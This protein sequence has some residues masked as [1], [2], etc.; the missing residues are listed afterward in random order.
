MAFIRIKKGDKENGKYLFSQDRYYRK[1]TAPTA[2]VEQYAETVNAA[3]VYEVSVDEVNKSCTMPEV[4]EE[5]VA[6]YYTLN[7][8]WSNGTEVFM[9]QTSSS[10]ERVSNIVVID[11]NTQWKSES[12]PHSF[13]LSNGNIVVVWEKNIYTTMGNPYTSQCTEIFAKIFASD[14]TVVKETFQVSKKQFF[15]VW[16]THREIIQDGEHATFTDTGESAWPLPAGFV[17]RNLNKLITKQSNPF[18]VCLSDDSFVIFWDNYSN[19]YYP[20]TGNQNSF[21]T[22]NQRKKVCYSYFDSSGNIIR[23]TGGYATLI[24]DSLLSSNNEVWMWEPSATVMSDDKVYY[25]CTSVD[26]ASGNNKTK[27]AYGVIDPLHWTDASAPFLLND[28]RSLESYTNYDTH[29]TSICSLNSTPSYWVATWTSETYN[30]DDEFRTSPPSSTQIGD[31][32][33]VLRQIMGTYSATLSGSD[34]IIP[35]P[36]APTESGIQA[37]IY[38]KNHQINSDV[39]GLVNG[40][41]V[42]VWQSY[43]QDGSGWGIYARIFNHIGYPMSHE[44]PVNQTTIN[45]QYNPSVTV[46]PDG[47]FMVSWCDGDDETNNSIKG[48]IYTDL[49]VPVGEEFY[50]IDATGVSGLVTYAG[51]AGLGIG[52]NQ[53]VRTNTGSYNFFNWTG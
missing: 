6:T 20:T 35:Y 22:P 45:N 34:W 14:G 48:R 51:D 15:D 30:F 44:I 8:V 23:I 21:I 1:I 42:M 49:G 39:K 5:P 32:A 33:A 36:E 16:D 26:P 19:L 24:S 13:C 3:D 25:T 52:S 4:T 27:I 18:G 53:K 31:S 17:T 46:M 12:S 47:N 9:V 29:S 2:E 10:G 43:N 7:T 50:I 38:Y 40:G 28:N 11:T 37:N 41:F